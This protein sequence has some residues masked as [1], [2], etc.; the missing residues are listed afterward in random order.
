MLSFRIRQLLVFCSLC[1]LSQVTLAQSGLLSHYSFDDCTFRDV[2]AGFDGSA[3]GANTCDC[4]VSTNAFSFDGMLQTAVLDTAISEEL[5]SDDWSISMYIRVLNQGTDI[6]DILYLGS[7]CRQDSVFSFKFLPNTRRFR[8]VISQSINSEF[9]LDATLDDNSCWQYV[10]I[11][12]ED[13]TARMYINGLLQDEQQTGANLILTVP[14]LLTIANS[15]CQVSGVN[16]DVKFEGLLDELKIFD[17][18]L[19]E[20]EIQDADLRIDKIITR[21]TTIFAGS[22]IRLQTG[23]TCSNNFGWSPSDFLDDDLALNPIAT[24]ENDVTY[25]FTVQEADCQSIDQ[26]NIRIADPTNLTCEGLV[27]PTAFTPNDDRIN[28]RFGISNSFLIGELRSFEIFNR[29]GGR[30]FLT[31]DLNLTWDGMHQGQ[32]APASSYVYRVS[33]VCENQ[34]FSKSGIVNLI[35]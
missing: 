6:V 23:G 1:L 28:D 18:A 9:R 33:Y 20:R 22:S 10:V 12:K 15:P 2:N 17:R 34:L 7:E 16:P 11:T 5:S 32:Q 29:L 14:G 8:C 26:V 19:T 4:G 35:R 13:R 30:V 31:N 27:L 3:F 21:D 24:P 25:T